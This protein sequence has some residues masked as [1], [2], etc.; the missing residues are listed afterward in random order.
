M[1]AWNMKTGFRPTPKNV[2]C[3]S[4]P[5][6]LL[7]I[8]DL[9]LA[10]SEAEIG[11]EIIQRLRRVEHVRDACAVAFGKTAKIAFRHSRKTMRQI[12]EPSVE[13]AGANITAGQ[14]TARGPGWLHWRKMRRKLCQRRLC[15]TAIG[16]DLAADDMQQRWTGAHI[17]VQAIVP[18]DRGRIAG[19]VIVERANA[20]KAPD[21]H[22]PRDRVAEKPICEIEQ[23]VDFGVRNMRVLG[24]ALK[25]LVGGSDQREGVLEGQREDDAAIAVL[26]QVSLV[27]AVETRDDDMAA[28]DEPDAR[29]RR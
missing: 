3:R 20:G 1:R 4:R 28:F 9:A 17:Q 22:L 8:S 16:G 10:Q 13:A 19:A 23:V 11:A 2:F 5:L 21:D 27:R 6:F 25:A 7:Q 15:E 18:A 12:V 26:K 24:I 29:Q 14:R